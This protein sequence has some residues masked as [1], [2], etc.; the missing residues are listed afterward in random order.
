[1]HLVNN[2]SLKK[3]FSRQAFILVV[4][5]SLWGHFEVSAQISDKSIRTPY[6]KTKSPWVLPGLIEAENHDEGTADDPS[7]FDTNKGSEAPLDQFY[8]NTDVDYGVDTV[9]NL[10]DAAWIYS[11][12]WLEYSV[13]VSK[14]AV[15]NFVVRIATINDNQRLHIEFDGKD[16][17]GSLI[18]PNTG[19]WGSDLNG[20]HCFEQPVYYGLK[21]IKGVHRMR[22]AM[23]SGLYTIDWFKFNLAE[24]DSDITYSFDDISGNRSNLNG[25][26]QG[27]DF[28]KGNWVS[29]SNADGKSRYACFSNPKDT[30]QTFTLPPGKVLKKITLVGSVAGY[31]SITDGVNILKKGKVSTKPQTIIT[32][33]K[34][35]GAKINA[36]FSVSQCTI[37]SSI[38]YGNP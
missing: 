6:N 17:S 10:V 22:I 9:L 18:L 27:I 15:Y 32:N 5:G 28:G 36:S 19:C 34:N 30:I 25:V 8:R 2:S 24:D 7:Y 13:Y 29:H 23:D 26:H 1:M 12:E 37:V 20:S 11:S 21:L 33:W 38:T 14:T 3:S 35:A 16:V 4:L 31:Y